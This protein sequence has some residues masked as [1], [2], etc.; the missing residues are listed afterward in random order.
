MIRIR[1]IAPSAALALLAWI[2]AHAQSLDLTAHDV[3]VSIGDS[4]RTVGL[5]LNFRDRRMEE[6]IGAN[7]T[8]WYPYD[9]AVGGVVR[10][11]ALG[12]PLTGARRIDGIG[13]GLLGVG[14]E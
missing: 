3:G 14:V 1:V 10:G 6:V 11:L 4:R 5:R 8:V 13:A 9:D 2:P 7:L 12:V